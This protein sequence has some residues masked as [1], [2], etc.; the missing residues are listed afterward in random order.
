MGPGLVRGLVRIFCAA[1]GALASFAGA[2]FAAGASNPMLQPVPL[3]L[4]STPQPRTAADFLDGSAFE[5]SLAGPPGAVIASGYTLSEHPIAFAYGPPGPRTP[6]LS[7]FA[8]TVALSPELALDLGYGLD[9]AGRFT[10]YDFAS[11]FDGLF[12]SPSA[13][14]SGFTPLGGGSS[15]LGA[16]WSIA[17]GLH[18]N[19]GEAD[20][21]ANS[22]PFASDAFSAIG[23]PAGALLNYSE[24]TAHSLMAGVA[25][26]FAHWGGVEASASRTSEHQGLLNDTLDNSTLNLAAHVKFGGGWVT[27]ASYGQAMTKLDVKPSALAL[28]SSDVLHRPTYALAIAKHGV[29]GDDALGLSVSQPTASGSETAGFAT[30]DGGESAPVYIGRDHLLADLKPETDIEVGYVTTFLDGSLALQTNAAYQMNFAG[31]SGTNSL[32]LLSRAKIKF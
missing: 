16:S 6:D 22:E 23:Q 31:Q 14:S 25:W 17:D 7:N 2:G 18:L 9:D 3:A 32:S 15:Y 28:D 21:D 19:V 26:N 10:R 24:R 27:T 8:A 12:L 29:F 11:A 1:V 5:A 13:L 20:T 30:V 4:T